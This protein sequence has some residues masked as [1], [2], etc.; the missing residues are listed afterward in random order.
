[1]N[2]TICRLAT[3]TLA[4]SVGISSAM[5][6][7]D[8][9]EAW[10][11]LQEEKASQTTLGTPTSTGGL[12]LSMADAVAVSR[13]KS[14]R[15]WIQDA[16]YI[17]HEYTHRSQLAALFP[18]LSLAGSYS[19]TLKKQKMYFDG[20][21]GAEMMPGMDEG[22][23][24][25]RTHNVQGGLQAALP[26]VNF[27]LWKSLEISDAGVEMALQQ[28][29]N[30]RWDS[31]MEVRKAYY[32]ALLAQ[33]SM[34]AIAQSYENARLNYESVKKKFDQGLVAEFDLL[35]A[36]VSFAQIE[37]SM[38]QAQSAN[39][40]ARKQLAVLMGLESQVEIELSDTWES[41]MAQ[42]PPQ[43]S[44][45][46]MDSL[47]KH[48][49]SLQLLQRQ[50][51][52][53]AQSVSLSR[54]SLLPSLSLGFGY[55]YSF[56]GNAWEDFQKK[57]LWTPFSSV[58]LN[59]S[60]PLFSGGKDYYNTKRAQADLLIR[61]LQNQ[62][63]YR[64]SALALS[65][66]ESKAQTAMQKMATTR[67]TEQSAQKGYDIAQKRYDSGL[68]TQLEINDAQLALMQAR[69]QY[70]QSVYDYLLARLE[71]EKLQGP[72][73]EETEEEVEAMKLRMQDLR[74]VT[75]F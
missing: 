4:V 5:A 26:L 20:F 46:G 6:Q 41:L 7:S 55:H 29:K 18:S 61:Q 44:G 25:G 32:M 47:V 8:P 19:Y 69:L 22:I 3:L 39:Q 58:S 21:P 74:R 16:E 38:L 71:I 14:R 30:S 68:G 13:N 28:A 45:W 70:T 1:M 65:D 60:M 11:R 31:D 9:I 66:Q 23:E 48:N 33:E 52:M 67:R 51:A 35:R 57:K 27:S 75:P 24:M 53:L 64:Q 72:R 50:E 12:R 42:L 17:K 2:R 43:E 37:P 40:L 36:E 63:L 34:E 62:D 10:N 73:T 59:F 54:Y 49:P 56:A 15:L